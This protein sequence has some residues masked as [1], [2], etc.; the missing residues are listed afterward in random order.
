[1]LQKSLYPCSTFLADISLPLN[2]A[3]VLPADVR[4]GRI[5]SSNS[6]F[7]SIQAGAPAHSRCI[8]PVVH[9]RSLAPRG[10]PLDLQS[11]TPRAQISLA[12]INTRVHQGGFLRTVLAAGLIQTTHTQPKQTSPNPTLPA[13]LN[14]ET[15]ARVTRGKVQCH[16]TLTFVGWGLLSC[17]GEE[18]V[19]RE[20]RF[21]GAGFTLL[22]QAGQRVSGPASILVLREA[23]SSACRY[24]EDGG[25]CTLFQ[26]HTSVQKGDL[27]RTQS[28]KTFLK[29]FEI[30]RRK[31]YTR[32]RIFL[33]TENEKRRVM[34]GMHTTNR[35]W[36][37]CV[38]ERV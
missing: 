24:A 7:S 33:L 3:L 1:M 29:V 6:V 13:C 36:F 8:S 11:L 15:G 17:C 2:R 10:S 5:R 19:F 9:Q 32:R 23:S 20:R 35:P 12:L 14:W 30:G 16:H 4:L 34:I 25:G 21:Y 26:A 38:S 18:G 31:K 28:T 22:S 37:Q 27:F